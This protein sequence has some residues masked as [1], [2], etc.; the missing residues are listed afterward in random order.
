MISSN[1]RKRTAKTKRKPGAAKTNAAADPPQ[2][3]PLVTTPV[4]P[5]AAKQ[6]LASSGAPGQPPVA[7]SPVYTVPKKRKAHTEPDDPYLP[8]GI[9]TGSFLLYPA[10][11]LIAG[12]NSNPAQVPGGKAANSYTAAPE[13]RV[14]SDWSRHELKADLRGSYTGYSPDETPSLSRPYFNGKVDGRVDVTKNDR[15][16]LGARALVS[17]DNP[18]SPNLQAGLSKLP[19]FTTTGGNAGYTHRFNR[20]EIGFKADVERTAYQDSKLTDGSTGSN[21][22]RD[23]NQYGGTLRAGYELSPGVTPFV[24]AGADSR[25]HDLATDF[26]GYQRDS[27]RL[28]SGGS[29]RPSNCRGC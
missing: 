3:V 16:D 25:K 2:V 9:R 14:Q 19:I 10:V 23:Y 26:S 27:Q 29:A 6:A 28:Y 8:L 15:I 5:P 1:A 21:A 7:L 12:R 13:L 4:L 24:E 22:D 18:G 11:E 20:L 17:T